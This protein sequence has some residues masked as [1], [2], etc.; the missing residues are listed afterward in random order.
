[1]TALPDHLTAIDG[2]FLELE[3][4]DSAAHMHMGG[5]LDLRAA[6]KRRRTGRRGGARLP[7]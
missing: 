5:L 3:D 6:S 7:R 2:T 4:A 1:M